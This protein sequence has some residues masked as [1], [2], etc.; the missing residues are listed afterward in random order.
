M[1][2]INCIPISAILNSLLRHN[3]NSN[4]FV[5]FSRFCEWFCFQ[6]HCAITLDSHSKSQHVFA[7][8]NPVW[9]LSVFW[10]RQMYYKSIWGKKKDSNSRRNVE[11]GWRDINIPVLTCSCKADWDKTKNCKDQLL[12]KKHDLGKTSEGQVLRV[13]VWRKLVVGKK[14][15]T[16]MRHWMMSWKAAYLHCGRWLIRRALLYL[17]SQ[18]LIST[19]QLFRDILA[20]NS[21]SWK[22]QYGTRDVQKLY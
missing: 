19:L 7:W 1:R 11:K 21:D 17:Q 3:F 4:I 16:F 9:W 2:S 10:E 15:D 12:E 8:R 20:S 6:M 18:H 5:L 13:G 22:H 14:Y